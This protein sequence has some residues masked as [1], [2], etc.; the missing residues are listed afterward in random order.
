MI[1][2][3]T[4]TISTSS[5]YRMRIYSEDVRKA[6]A[7][8]L[9]LVFNHVHREWKIPAK[10]WFRVTASGVYSYEEIVEPFCKYETTPS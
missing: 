4:R 8:V 9:H 7:S 3:R 6:G 1:L 10:A 2:K 5:K